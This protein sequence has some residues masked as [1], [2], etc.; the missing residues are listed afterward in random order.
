MSACKLYRH[1]DADGV[2]LYVGITSSIPRRTAEHASRSHWSDDAVSMTWETF[3]TREEALAAERLAIAAEKP[4]HNVMRPVRPSCAPSEQ[5]TFRRAFVEAMQQANATVAD[6]ALETGVSRDVINKLIARPG[7]S[8]SAENA[9]ALAAY[10]G[11]TLNQLMAAPLAKRAIGDAE[12][13]GA[14]EDF[15]AKTG[16]RPSIFGRAAVNDGSLVKQLQE[17]REL[18]G[19]TRAKVLTFISTHR[20]AS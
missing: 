4:L 5:G 18:L 16:M 11:K 7:S 13:L 1:F 15:L 10:F 19:K 6:I 8:T 2:L 20:A 17:G 14:I 3:E 12:L 9:V